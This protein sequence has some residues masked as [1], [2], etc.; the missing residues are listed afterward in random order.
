[1][2]KVLILNY[3]QLV[4]ENSDLKN[5]FTLTRSQFL[6]QISTIQ[7]KN[8][9]FVSFSD[10]SN[11]LTNANVSILLT[12]DDGQRSDFEI[13][14]PILKEKGIPA[15]FFPIVNELEK[16]NKMTWNEL[17]KLAEDGFEIGSHGL[18]HKNLLS[19]KK[20]EIHAE[21]SL[22]KRILEEKLRK[23]VQILAFPYGN[24]NKTCLQIAKENGY[25]HALT[26]KARIN[27]F[28]LEF[29]LHR[30]NMKNTFSQ[31]EFERIISLNKWTYL[32]RKIGLYLMSVFFGWI[33]NHANS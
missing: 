6:K 8:I 28:P 17:K 23:S 11:G 1:M 30:W 16:E 25:Q 31:I 18:S 21:I 7:E 4:D 15:A 13:A 10:I 3:H 12:F 27:L 9:P 20:E 33:K 19:L 29:E 14:Y 5:R 24:Y 2:S 22:S 26:T 32:K